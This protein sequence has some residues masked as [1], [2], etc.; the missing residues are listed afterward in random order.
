MNILSQVFQGVIRRL[1]KDIYITEKF[2]KLSSLARARVKLF[3]QAYAYSI[4]VI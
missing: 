4:L 3:L 2:K 1:S